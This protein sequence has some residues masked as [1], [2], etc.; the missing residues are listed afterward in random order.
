VND[1]DSE[2]MPDF[3]VAYAAELPASTIPFKSRTQVVTD[4]VVSDYTKILKAYSNNQKSKFI[5]FSP[6]NHRLH[7]AKLDRFKTVRI[8]TSK[9]VDPD[10]TLRIMQ[11]SEGCITG[12][13]HGLMFCLLLKVPFVCIGSNTRK[14]ESALSESVGDL[15]RLISV[16]EIFDGHPVTVPSLTEREYANIQAYLTF[17]QSSLGRLR[18]AFSG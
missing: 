7:L 1:I 18:T 5:Y 13:F 10:N 9:F 11:N 6:I 15:S 3:S 12:R 4:S 8:I 17:A 2:F 14:V 16:E